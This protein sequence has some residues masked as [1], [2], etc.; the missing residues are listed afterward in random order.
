MFKCLIIFL[1]CIC[2]LVWG[3][4]PP[5]L[6]VYRTPKISIAGPVCSATKTKN[7]Y[8]TAV[9]VSYSCFYWT[10]VTIQ[11]IIKGLQNI[12]LIIG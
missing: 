12:S 4:A 11:K 8:L 3:E 9:K 6:S 2:V 1:S 7:T 5:N 10:L